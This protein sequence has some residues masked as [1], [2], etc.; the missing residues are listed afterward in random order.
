MLKKRVVQ[1]IV[2][3]GVVA[4]LAACTSFGNGAHPVGSSQNA[5]KPGLYTSNKTVS[6]APDGSCI[7]VRDPSIKL[8]NG[9]GDDAEFG[10][11]SFVQVLPTDATIFSQG[12]G[13][14]TAPKSTSYNPDRATARTGVY[15]I[16]TDLLPGTYTAP[17][18]PL[19]TWTRV[20]SF[21]GDDASIIAA[22]N[23]VGSKTVHG[24]T[25]PRV[26]IAKTDVGFLTDIC[27]GWRRVGP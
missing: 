8:P 1:A 18:G 12:C 11:R 15:R 16:P 4:G 14:W 10:G 26:T 25:N 7:W 3:V 23:P 27:G 21:K 13:L 19:C 6:L 24:V 17:G 2:T 5:V 22:S 20:S 9:K